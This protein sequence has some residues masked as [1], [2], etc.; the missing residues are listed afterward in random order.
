MDIAFDSKNRPQLIETNPAEAAGGTSGFFQNPI[1]TDAIIGAAKG[2]LPAFVKAK[3]L[4]YGIGALG[5]GGAG[6]PPNGNTA[7]VIGS[8]GGISYISMLP[9]TTAS[10]VVCTSGAA[11]AGG[12]SQASGGAGET[13]S[14]TNVA[15]F[16]SLG[17][18]ISTAG[19]AGGTSNTGSPPNVT[20]LTS[21]ITCGG[22]AGAGLSLSVPFSGGSINSSSISSQILGSPAS[23]TTKPDTGTTLFKPFFSLG[24]A[25]GGS[26]YFT[27]IT[28][29]GDGGLGSGGG[30]GGLLQN[31]GSSFTGGNGGNG[32]NGLV[33]IVSF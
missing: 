3:R 33:I 7:V 4:A 28:G 19:Q 23:P 21:Q 13:A 32:G 24:G 15:N 9:S 8:P 11:G 31:G 12:G 18:F 6:G 29:G 5:L 14:T 25:G 22:A 17:H 10:N 16:L 1:V 30:G 2:D 27:N 20:P 26:G